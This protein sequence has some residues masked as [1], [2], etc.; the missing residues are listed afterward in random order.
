MGNSHHHASRAIALTLALSSSKL[1]CAQGTE[2]FALEEVV[3]TAQKR[4]ENLQE[5]P[6]AVTALT[7]DELLRSGVKD[8]Q[9]LNKVAPEVN[10][11]PQ[12]NGTVVSIRGVRANSFGPAQDSAVGLHLDGAYLARFQG[13]A[14]LFFDVQNLEIAQ[15]PQG[16]L[17]GRNTTGGTMNVITT[18]PAKEF[19]GY[20][21]LEGGN[22]NLV[23]AEG[24]LNLPIADNFAV[25]FAGRHY[26]HS[27]Y[28]TDTGLDD[29]NQNS[30]RLSVLLNITDSQTLTVTGNITKQTGK[31]IGVNIISQGPRRYAFTT[32]SG[33][34]NNTDDFGSP[35]NLAGNPVSADGSNYVT[36]SRA[37]LPDDPRHNKVIAGDA[38]KNFVDTTLKAIN[39]QYD[40]NL[41]SAIFTLQ[42]SY[43]D[44]KNLYGSGNSNAASE[45]QPFRVPAGF[46]DQLDNWKSVEARLTSVA[47]DPL[48][49]VVGLYY[50]DED[51]NQ[52]DFGAYAV[53]PT[54]PPT[55]GVF[56][57]N[58]FT[59]TAVIQNNIANDYALAT[60]YAAFTQVDWKVIDKLTL[61][62]GLRYNYDKKS[63]RII[64]YG[65]NGSI[66]QNPTVPNPF[67]GSK[68][69]TKFTYKLA[70]RYDLT[71]AHH[72]YATYSTAYK[73]G[74]FAFGTHPEYVPQ[75]MKAFE[76]GS[77][78]EFMNNR[79]RLN[80]AA[81]YYKYT[82][83]ETTALLCLNETITACPQDPT[84]FGN[85]QPTNQAIGVTNAGG[86]HIYGASLALEALV[87]DSDRI[88]A[89]V[90]WL[91]AKYETFDL[92][93]TAYVVPAARKDYT[94]TRLGW[95]ADW[96][97]NGSFTHA[98]NLGDAGTL[99]AQLAVQYISE[100]LLG[101]QGIPGSATYFMSDPETTM[102]FS[103]RYA[104]TGG[105][106]DLTAYCN[107]LTD[108]LV[109][110]S[111]GRTQVNNLVSGPVTYFF[112]NYAPPRTYGLIAKVK[113]GN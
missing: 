2:E 104:P 52:A 58:P 99:D 34:I 7:A 32:A 91:D 17:Y 9:T 105:A 95:A 24:A 100:R 49:W 16:T 68:D 71:S 96:S 54:S 50:F 12:N 3:V 46:G 4:A 90:Q 88:N 10:V 112:A 69:W 73:A 108:E 109:E 29:A 23:A 57:A 31:N 63:A 113:F 106:W 56:P 41:S 70:A 40:L 37:V 93:K 33:V 64:T 1:L 13:I 86:A 61:T 21:S 42:G 80:G 25:R 55:T 72:I 15:G 87:T 84:L 75:N 53:N 30:G 83:Y 19:G 82:D 26:K 101:N 45:L 67:T 14:G 77:K 28:F 94:G 39:A 38:D 79:I 97:A 102:D 6:I 43:F 85:F 51:L 66:P 111:M 36:S 59:G 22:Y 44:L 110:T 81:W 8:F 76:I 92:S 18:K 47:T 103:I 89:Y 60:A 62:G 107:N 74:G 20:A 27:G 35:A 48:R 11:N 65:L 78:N 5:T 98:W